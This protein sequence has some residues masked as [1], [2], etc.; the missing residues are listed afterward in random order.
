MCRVLSSSRVEEHHPYF[1]R[2]EQIISAPIG[3]IQ[4]IPTTD[5][6]IPMKTFLGFDN[7]IVICH[8]GYFRTV[9]QPF[10]QQF[11]KGNVDFA[12]ITLSGV[13]LV[14]V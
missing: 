6:T 13:F 12:W 2:E 1:S 10:L 4:F 5:H 7:G 8:D 11:P 9:R 3:L 14:G